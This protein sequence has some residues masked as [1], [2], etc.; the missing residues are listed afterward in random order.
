MH[1]TWANFTLGEADVLRDAMGK[2]KMDVLKMQ[3][4]KF[5]E[6]AVGNN[7]KAEDAEEVY[8]YLEPFGRYAFNRS[9]TVA[10]QSS[11]IRPLISRRTIPVSLWRQ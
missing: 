5:I 2:K 7:I 9:H 10:M 8:E 6:G 3:R 11:P 4:E 1:G